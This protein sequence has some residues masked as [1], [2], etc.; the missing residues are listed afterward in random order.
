M[1]AHFPYT[2][3]VLDGEF[4]QACGDNW[5]CLPHRK[6]TGCNVCGHKRHGRVCYNAVCGC[7]S[8]TTPLQGDQRPTSHKSGD[9]A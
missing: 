2:N 5:P 3:R 8:V 6:A 4:C 1:T 7:G 9:S